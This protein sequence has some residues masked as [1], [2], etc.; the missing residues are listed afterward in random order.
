MK[1]AKVIGRVFCSRQCCGMDSKTLLLIQPLDW[2]TD[3]PS[4]DP[5]VA[6]DTVGAGAGETVFFVASREAIVAFE[7]CEGETA[8]N[9]PLPPVDAAIVGIIDGKQLKS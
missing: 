7:G 6:G 5:L 3:K 9:M 1:Q 8:V 2:E 4:G